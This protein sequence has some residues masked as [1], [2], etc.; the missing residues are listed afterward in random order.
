MIYSQVCIIF[1]QM[2]LIYARLP[3]IS[4]Q[5]DGGTMKAVKDFTFVGSKITK[6]DDCSHEIKRC[7]LLPWWLR[8]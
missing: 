7:L 1:K 5:I 2:F 8:W 4:P 6:D 3:P